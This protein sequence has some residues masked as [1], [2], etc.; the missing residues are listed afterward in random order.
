VLESASKI[1]IL[2][3]PGS[4]KSTLARKL[5]M[6]T[7]IPHIEVDSLYWEFK[8]GGPVRA[9]FT[10]RLADLLAKE[11][12]IVEGQYRKI[13]GLL[14]VPD[15]IL[16]LQTG[17]LKLIFRLALRDLRQFANG[18]RKTS[19]LAWLIRNRRSLPKFNPHDLETKW[20]THVESIKGSTDQRR[21]SFLIENQPIE[22]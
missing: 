8:K 9:D 2:G 1:L 12:W 18:S 3:L 5:S 21:V 16:I 20:S 22:G 13:E 10:V 11:A 4:G 14:P 7:G 19:D 17:W 15:L 6:E